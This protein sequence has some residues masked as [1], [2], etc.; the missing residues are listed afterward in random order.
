MT[1]CVKMTTYSNPLKT[2]A[3]ILTL[4]VVLGL[5]WGP[6]ASADELDDAKA[7]GLVGET[8]RG[9]LAPVN[10]ATPAVSAL[11]ERINTARRARYAEIAEDT[12]GTVEEV[13]LLTAQRVIE[14]AAPGAYILDQSNTWRQK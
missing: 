12:G 2:F 6:G 8:W 4:V 11:V 1:Y 14:R 13:G 9:Y 5:S 3:V 10:A 7:A